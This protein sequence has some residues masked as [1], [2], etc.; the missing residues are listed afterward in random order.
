V[1]EEIVIICMPV[2][3]SGYVVPGAVQVKCSGCQELVWV[4]PSSWLVM[5][6]NPGSKVLC[7]SCGADTIRANPGPMKFGTRA[8]IEEVEEWRRTQGR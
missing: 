3:A 4:A 1:S 7:W 8:Q 5:A 2:T 6:D